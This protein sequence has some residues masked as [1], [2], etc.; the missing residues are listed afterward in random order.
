MMFGM[1]FGMSQRTGVIAA[2]VPN[3]EIGSASAVLALVRNVAGA[4]GI[5]IFATILNISVENNMLALSAHSVINVHTPVVMQTVS[6]L[7]Y[8]DAEILAYRT[9]FLIGSVILVIAA[10]LA[11]LIDVKKS[12]EGKEIVL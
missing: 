10:V 1:G 9:V 11:L 5:A 8:L 6:A 7:M 4:F 12:M 3:E 2:I